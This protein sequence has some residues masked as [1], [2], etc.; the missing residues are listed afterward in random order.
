MKDLVRDEALRIEN[1]EIAP[2]GT[3]IFRETRD[4]PP[5]NPG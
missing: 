4:S 1:D 3:D 5:G 2:L